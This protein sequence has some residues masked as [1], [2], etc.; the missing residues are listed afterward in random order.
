MNVGELKEQLSTIP[1]TAEVFGY[2]GADGI[3]IQAEGPGTGELN[4]CAILRVR[5]AAPTGGGPAE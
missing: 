5:A 3:L 1:D 4:R 2:V